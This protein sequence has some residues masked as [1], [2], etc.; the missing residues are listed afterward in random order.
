MQYDPFWPFYTLDCAPRSSLYGQRP[1]LRRIGA[2]GPLLS[3]AEARLHL[4]LDP[5]PLHSTTRALLPDADVA[6]NPD[7]ALVKG[8]LLAVQ[9]EVDGWSGF[10]NRA[11]AEQ[12]WELSFSSFPTAFRLPLPPFREILS[13]KSL[14]L[15]GEWVDVDEVWQVEPGDV[16]QPC[17]LFRLQPGG[18]WPDLPNYT[19]APLSAVQIRFKAGYQAGDPEL[20]LV[21]AYA[22]LRLGTFYENRESSLVGTT[23][24][25]L[26]GFANM[27]E[28]VRANCPDFLRS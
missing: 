3:F 1:T 9:A 4:K 7:D 24:V 11:V 17:A 23:A 2:P 27:L 15:D 10:L 18:V 19:Y 22:K 14:G 16:A 20:E 8:L 21:K 5:L 28:N 13:V 12:T 6:P 26:P 25:D